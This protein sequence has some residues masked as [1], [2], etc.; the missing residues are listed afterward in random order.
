[1][2]YNREDWYF[3]VMGERNGVPGLG[4]HWMVIVNRTPHRSSARS[5][6]Q[7]Q[8]AGLPTTR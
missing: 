5:D 3:N 1:M 7:Q 4:E 6:V 2:Q 8:R